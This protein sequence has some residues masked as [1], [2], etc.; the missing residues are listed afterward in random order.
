MIDGLDA[1][2]L[3]LFTREPRIGVLE[4][5]RRL[6]VARGTVQARLDR[7]RDTGVIAT[8]A[9]T[10]DP[11]ALGFRVTAFASLDIRQGARES[12]AAHLSRIPEVL[13]VHTITGQGDL[14]CRIVARDNDDL[15]RVIDDLVGDADIVRTSTLIAL[16]TVV[17][18]R[19]LPLV[20]SAA[21][22]SANAPRTR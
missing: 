19:V 20:E 12:V 7:L 6:Q 13:E 10:V 22:S 1:R 16:S 15:Q 14:L 8:F 18:P 9:P 3:E 11:A 4:A 17:G 21:A 2:I 5:S